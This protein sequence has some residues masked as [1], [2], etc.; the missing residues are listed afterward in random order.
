M[1]HRVAALTIVLPDR[2]QQREMHLHVVCVEQVHEPGEGAVLRMQLIEDRC[3]R[4]ETRVRHVRLV[5][6][7]RR[8]QA[9]DPVDVG[10]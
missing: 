1:S 9:E 7:E 5:L 2:V 8:T 10:R 3:L 6:Q 4:R